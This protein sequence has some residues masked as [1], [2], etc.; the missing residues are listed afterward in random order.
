MSTMVNHTVKL[1]DVLTFGGAFA[2]SIICGI[3]CI[4]TPQTWNAG[5]II[6]L[7]G[8]VL[9]LGFIA[10]QIT[11]KIWVDRPTFI[12]RQGAV[13]WIND[14]AITQGFQ[15]AMLEHYIVTLPT[16]TWQLTETQLR[17]MV[18][19]MYVEWHKDPVSLIAKGW[20]VTGKAGLQSGYG[21]MIQS[22]PTIMGT[23]AI[24]VHETHHMTQQMV[25]GEE[26]DYAHANTAWWAL[27]D[28]ITNSFTAAQDKLAGKG[29]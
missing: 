9:S 23:V 10:W 18:N 20:Y 27:A 21:E 16:L 25:L 24:F 8:V 4:A 15:E 1:A 28:Q 5:M 29:V 11:K 26:T 3:W 19:K 2:F 13:V 14:T 22:Q 7:S 12:T 17:S 6:S